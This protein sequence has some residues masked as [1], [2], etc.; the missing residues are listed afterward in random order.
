M[1]GNFLGYFDKPHS[2]VKTALATFGK[3]GLPFTPTSGHTVWEYQNIIF[4]LF[5][6]QNVKNVSKMLVP[7]KWS[8]VTRC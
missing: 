3:I 4:G 8:T 7:G 6:S 2:Y 5:L 1:I